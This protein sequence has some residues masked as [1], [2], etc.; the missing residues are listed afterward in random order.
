[1]LGKCT[2]VQTYNVVCFVQYNDGS[3]YI[4]TVHLS[5]LSK[6]SNKC[7]YYSNSELSCLEVVKRRPRNLVVVGSNPI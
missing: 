5:C 4:Y 7:S 6:G 1:M 3:L 2:R